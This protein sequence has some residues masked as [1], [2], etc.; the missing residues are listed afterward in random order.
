MVLLIGADQTVPHPSLPL[1]GK[2]QILQGREII[3]SGKA[4]ARMATLVR[5]E[6][7]RVQTTAHRVAHGLTEL[8]AQV[9]TQK[10]AAMPAVGEVKTGIGIINRY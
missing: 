4:A 7:V 2:E 5:T 3:F 10:A 8:V 1:Q 9:E 6:T